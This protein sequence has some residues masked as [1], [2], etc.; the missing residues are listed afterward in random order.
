MLATIT[1]A[2]VA[3]KLSYLRY[4]CIALMLAA[5]GFT[6]AQ[7]RTNS[8]DMVA[9]KAPMP[10][11]KV[12]GMLENIEQT[13]KGSKLY[14]SNVAIEGLNASETPKRI[15]LTL[16]SYD[17]NLRNGQSISVLAGLFPPP[18]AAL[19]G[20]FDF[21]RHYYFKGIG[22]VG[23]GMPPVTVNTT[24]EQSSFA[25]GF[26]ELRHRVTQSIRAHFDEPAGS[27]AAAFVTGQTASIPESVNEDMR[28][29]GI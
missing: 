9:L 12:T 24:P 21:A 25:I 14:L 5:L 22:A 10:F 26:S 4:A 2:Y 29:A 11:A 20:G 8:M 17:D 15:T 23:Y 19:P 6:L 27:I 13:P 1:L 7:I 28:I 3:R 18:Q 16:K